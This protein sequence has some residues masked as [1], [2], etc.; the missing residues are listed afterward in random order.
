MRKGRVDEA[1]AQYQEALQLKPDMAQAHVNLGNAL[2]QKGNV[3]EAIAHFQQALRIEPAQ[4]VVENNLAWLL[5][6]CSKASVRNG[7]AA[8]ELASQANE[9]TGGKNPTILH[10]L[11]A[12]YAEAG[13]FSDAVETAQRALRLAEAQNDPGL[14]GALQSELI[15]YQAGKPFHNHGPTQ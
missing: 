13:R 2:L 10:T 11:A 4:P 7:K 8:V 1:V 9:L 5:A 6:A 12:A 14:V 15:L 3:V